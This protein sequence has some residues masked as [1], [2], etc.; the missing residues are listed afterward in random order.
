MEVMVKTIA[1]GLIAFVACLALIVF[2]LFRFTLFPG[3]GTRVAPPLMFDAHRWQAKHNFHE[4]DGERA[5]MAEDLENLFLHTGM[6]RH[7]TRELLGAPDASSGYDQEKRWDVYDLGYRQIEI[8][9]KELVFQFDAQDRLKK[10]YVM[11]S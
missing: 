11:E 6:P 3:L 10:K 5:R 8:D 7:R 9:P 1:T 2:A 4:V